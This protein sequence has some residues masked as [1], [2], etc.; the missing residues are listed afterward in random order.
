[1]GGRVVTRTALVT[2][3]RSPAALDIA[4]DLAAAGLAVHMAD[5]RRACLARWSRT[6]AKVHRFASPVH[7][8]AGFHRDIAA[9]AAR[10]KPVLVVP[11]CEEVF[12]LAAAREDGVDVGPLFA[13]DVETLDRLHAKD[14][15]NALVRALG[16]HAPETTVLT[17]PVTPGAFDWDRI[18]LKACY[19][20]FGA[21]TLVRP[22]PA[23]AAGVLP[24]PARPWI[25]QAYAAGVEHSSYAVAVGGRVTAF[26]AYRLTRRLAGGAGYAFRTADTGVRERMLDA[27]RAVAAALGATGQIALDAI[28]DGTR[29]WLIE[30]NPRATSGAHMLAGGGRLARAIAGC[31]EPSGRGDG[32]WYNL[33]LM[34][35]HGL[36]SA[37]GRSGLSAALRD[38]RDVVGRPGDKLPLLGAVADTLGFAASALRG[39][40]TLTGATTGDIEW[41]GA[42]R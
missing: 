40:T 26:A 12:H 11:T 39:R 9:L 7:D 18:V 5:S 35:T 8:P 10:L 31:E 36:A 21:E 1:M 22:T 29:S 41:N 15:F 3:A 27:T 25:A 16:L 6:P 33:P 23:Q 17:S 28:D 19:G 42:R 2:G 34:L 4:R 32:E 30:C 14:R 20:R 38:G 13:P 24:T 37:R